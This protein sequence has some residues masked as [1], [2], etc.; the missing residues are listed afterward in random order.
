LIG[1]DFSSHP[2]ELPAR[3]EVL[4]FS[5][6]ADQILGIG[7]GAFLKAA[8]MPGATYQAM[9]EF[10]VIAEKRMPNMQVGRSMLSFYSRKQI[11]PVSQAITDH[12]TETGSMKVSSV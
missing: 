8:E 1:A 3:H 4:V 2:S 6:E 9:L 7:H 5:Q 11:V 10:Q 12:K